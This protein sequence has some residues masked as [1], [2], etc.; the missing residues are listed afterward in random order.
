MGSSG[1]N[2]KR[3]RPMATASA[4][5]PAS[6]M[7]QGPANFFVLSCELVN[8]LPAY[9]GDASTR[10]RSALRS[11]EGFEDFVQPPDMALAGGRIDEAGLKT[12]A[13]QGVGMLAGEPRRRKS[14]GEVVVHVAA[15]VGRVIRIDGGRQPRVKQP[16]QVVAGQVRKHAALEVGQGADRQR[17]AVFGQAGHERG[18]LD[19]LHAVVDALDL[20]Q[21]ERGPDV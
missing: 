17:N 7:A 1:V 13:R 14:L 9:L 15:K 16:A 11:C 5:S 10:R 2:A 18:V 21:I 3:P 12:V 20:E 8:A 4:T 6:A 19:R